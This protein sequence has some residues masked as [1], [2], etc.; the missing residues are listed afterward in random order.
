MST[1]HT[2]CLYNPT[3][4]PVTEIESTAR[5]LLKEKYYEDNVYL[6]DLALRIESLVDQLDLFRE[7]GFCLSTPASILES[8]EDMCAM[9]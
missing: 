9:F 1:H 7:T 5:G 6:M 3:F 2:S 8:L 4:F